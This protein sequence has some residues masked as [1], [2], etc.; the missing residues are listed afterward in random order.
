MSELITFSYFCLLPKEIRFMIWEHLLEP[1][2]IELEFHTYNLDIWDPPRFLYLLGGDF[3]YEHFTMESTERPAE[4]YYTGHLFPRRVTPPAG[5]AVHRESRDFFLS[6]GYRPWTLGIP[7]CK[8]M[9]VMWCPALDTI[10]F[11]PDRRCYPRYL[12]VFIQQFPT[13]LK[14]L[15]SI[16]LPSL[17]W[18]HNSIFPIDLKLLFKFE[19]LKEFV[20]L[21]SKEHERDFIVVEEGLEIWNQPDNRSWTLSTAVHESLRRAFDTLSHSEPSKENLHPPELRVEIADKSLRRE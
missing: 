19:A 17:Y 11:P 3:P 9:I 18:S 1:R 5:L 16:A 6:F 7:L 12:E 10:L 13:Q 21:L 20:L 15:E 8:P 14:E 4:P 2:L